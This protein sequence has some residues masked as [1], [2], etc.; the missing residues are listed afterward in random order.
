MAAELAQVPVV[1]AA[2][3]RTFRTQSS[4]KKA[5]LRERRPR[6]VEQDPLRPAVGR[7]GL[8]RGVA[9]G[10]QA[11]PTVLAQAAD[12]VEDHTGL[13][14]LVEV[15]AVAGDDVE[16]VVVAEAAEQ[17]ILEMVGGD[18]MLLSAVGGDEQRLPM[19]VASVLMARA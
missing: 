18:E 10:G 17:W 19:V 14:G 3:S 4:L 7:L 1:V 5:R 6:L 8:G 15:E 11:H 13:A 12:H 16:Q 2:S 9:N